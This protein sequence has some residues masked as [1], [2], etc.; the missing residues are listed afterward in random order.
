MDQAFARNRS[1][2]A[3]RGGRLGRIGT[4]RFLIM[5]PSDRAE[6]LVLTLLCILAIVPV[7]IMALAT[8]TR[9]EVSAGYRAC[10]RVIVRSWGRSSFSRD[11]CKHANS[12]LSQSRPQIVSQSPTPRS[13]AVLDYADIDRPIGRNCSLIKVSR[14]VSRGL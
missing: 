3:R 2:L 13:C 14:R 1:D 10:Q 12:S 9:L 6:R 8:I 11:L 5:K 4:D 7:T